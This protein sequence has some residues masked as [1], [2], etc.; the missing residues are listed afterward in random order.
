M[1]EKSLPVSKSPVTPGVN[2]VRQLFKQYGG[3]LSGMLVL[4]ILFSFMNDSFL[5]PIT[6][7]I[8]PFRFPLLLLP[9]TV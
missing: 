9:L 5:Q 4:I 2:G 6:L 7:S 3:I 1:S 8:L